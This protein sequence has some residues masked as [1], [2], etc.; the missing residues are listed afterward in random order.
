MQNYLG[1]SFRLVNLVVC[2]VRCVHDRV[3]N[4]CACGPSVCWRLLISSSSSSSSSCRCDWPAAASHR[5]PR[6]LRSLHPLR[7]QRIASQAQP[8]SHELLQRVVRQTRMDTTSNGMAT[9]TDCRLRCSGAA[10]QRSLWIPS[11]RLSAR[12]RTVHAC[13]FA[14]AVCSFRSPLRCHVMT[15]S[16]LAPHRIAGSLRLPPPSARPLQQQPAL[17]ERE[18][19]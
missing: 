15:A 13:Q 8:C 19:Q 12:P 18:S 2:R 10:Q 16:A 14:R 3:T 4:V 5:R 11:R 1:L 7:S 6:R 9:R 17:S